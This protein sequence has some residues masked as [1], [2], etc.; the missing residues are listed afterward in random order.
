MI[1]FRVRQRPSWILCCIALIAWAPVLHAQASASN[2]Q[3]QPQLIMPE[4][5]VKVLKSAGTKPLILNIGPW[6]LFVQAH[7]PGAEFIGQGSDPQA[8]QRLRDRVQKLPHNSYIVLYCGCCPWAHCPNVNPAYAELR[9]LGFTNVKVLY[10][11]DNL[12]TDWVYKGYPA[13]SGQ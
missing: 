9:R 4:D 11:A 8:L 5:L 7:I 13:V 1:I 3:A 12:G 10:V 6:L 2:T